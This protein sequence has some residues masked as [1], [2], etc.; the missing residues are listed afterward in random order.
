MDHGRILALDT[1]ERLIHAHGGRSVV[2]A[3]LTA[4]PPA[5]HRFAQHADGAALRIEC[6]RPFEVV[7]Q[8]AG[9]GVAVRTLRVETADLESVFLSLT[10]RRLR[11]E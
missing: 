9:D 7:A 11:D 1:V 4:P 10:G 6:E 2:H 5:T 8:L 3:E